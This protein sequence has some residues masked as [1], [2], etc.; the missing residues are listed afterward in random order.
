MMAKGGAI[1]IPIAVHLSCLKTD[2]LGSNMLFF[3]THSANSIKVSVE[4]VL[5]FL[6]SRAFLNGI[7]PYS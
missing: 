2:L 6:V 1:L 4:I 5:F 3:R 7:N